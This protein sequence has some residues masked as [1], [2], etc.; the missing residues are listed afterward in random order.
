MTRRDGDNQEVD[1]DDTAA[2]SRRGARSA[3]RRRGLT[4]AG[5]AAKRRLDVRHRVSAVVLGLALWVFG[6]LG[7]VD[8]LALFS[9]QGG[10]VLGLSSNGLL[11][12]ISLVVGAVLIGAAVR[13]G[14]TASTVTVVV[15]AAFLLSGMANVLVLDTPFNVLAFGMSNVIFSLLAGAV[16]VFFGAY[17]RFTGGLPSS[18]PYQQERHDRDDEQEQVP[19]PTIFSDP[20]DVRA[21]AELAEAERADAR[22]S[23]SPTQVT[24]LAAAREARRAEDRVEKWRAATDE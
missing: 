11:S 2:V 4:S 6:I 21:A 20:A 5:W 9:T 18:N 13:G 1:A 3:A 7:L 10:R 15:G 17:G 12:V 19:L 14:R 24:G 16:L 22:H 8:R 23:T